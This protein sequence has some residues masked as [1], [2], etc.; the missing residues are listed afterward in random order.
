[1]VRNMPATLPEAI[2]II[3]ELEARLESLKQALRY[4][5]LPAWVMQDILEENRAMK[6]KLREIGS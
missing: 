2:E 3:K 5:T 6:S 1:M 4:D